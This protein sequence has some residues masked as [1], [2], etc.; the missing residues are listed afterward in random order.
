MI[1]GVTVTLVDGDGNTAEDRNRNPCTT[2]TGPDGTYKFENLPSG[3][4]KVVFTDPS[5]SVLGGYALITPNAPGVEDDQDSDAEE[6]SQTGE[7]S[8]S[9]IE[10]MPDE[11]V[12]LDIPQTRLLIRMFCKFRQRPCCALQICF[13]F[14]PVQISSIYASTAREK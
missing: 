10:M 7:I 11:D 5:G 3:G 1:P 13:H 4:M 12:F 8:I 6:D 2:V 9:E 14:L